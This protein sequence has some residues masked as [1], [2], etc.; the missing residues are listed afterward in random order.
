[1]T[2]LGN[3]V[4]VGLLASQPLFAEVTGL[5][6]SRLELAPGSPDRGGMEGHGHAAGGPG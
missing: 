6:A 3:T 1:M 4:R 5:A 2:P